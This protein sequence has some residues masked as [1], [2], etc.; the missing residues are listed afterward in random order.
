MPSLTC[1]CGERI[2]LT[3]FP[4]D[5]EFPL[6]SETQ[7]EELQQVLASRLGN[8]TDVQRPREVSQIFT[9]R[10]PK[11]EIIECAV[12]GRLALFDDT[13]ADIPV[14]WYS[15]EVVNNPKRSRLRDVFVR[16]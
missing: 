16:Q 2:S 15:P 7:L 11:P 10:I 9:A 8:L 14:V 13:S 3:S 4:N 12:C 6:F 1:L 5:N